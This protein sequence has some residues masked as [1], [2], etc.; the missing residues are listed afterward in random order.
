MLSAEAVLEILRLLDEG[1][2]SRRDIAT[3]VGVCHGTV[4]NVARGKRG[5]YGPGSCEPPMSER[6]LGAPV[7]C[8]G[9]GGRVCQ[10]CLLCQARPIHERAL[11]TRRILRELQRSPKRHVA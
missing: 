11:V 10:P 6:R 7:R 2:H 4:N 8:R 5:I 3:M 9:C 1:N